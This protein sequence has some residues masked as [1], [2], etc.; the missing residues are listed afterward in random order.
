MNGLATGFPM[1]DTRALEHPEALRDALY[2]AGQYIAAPDRTYGV[3]EAQTSFYFKANFD[4]ELTDTV[5]MSGNVGVRVVNTNIRVFQNLTDGTQLDP[6]ILAGADPN[7]T[8]Y[9][10]LGDVYTTTDRTRALPSF[11]LNFDFGDEWRLKTAYY[12][13]QALQPLQNLGPR[14]DHVLQRR[15]D[16]R[17]LAAREQHPA[18]RQS[19]PRA[20]VVA[21]AVDQRRVVPARAHAAVRRRVLY[22]RRQLH[23]HAHRHRPDRAGFRWRGAPR[24]ADP[25]HRAG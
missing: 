21:L 4:T 18:P 9:T 6:R 3:E 12:E 19:A 15:T 11:N 16:R 25:G 14:P 8:A 13:T 7:H 1:I 23:L 10:D 17:D 2:G 22:R 24:C 20:L 5:G